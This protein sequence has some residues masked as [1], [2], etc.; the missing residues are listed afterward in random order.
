MMGA[1]VLPAIL[2]FILIFMESQITALIVSK[3]ERMLVKG[4]GFHVDLLIIVLVGGISAFFGLPWLSAATVRSVTHTNALTVMTK[5]NTPGE[6]P[7]ILEVKEQRV[8]GFLVAVFVGLSIVFGEA[9]RQI[10]LAVLF[11]IFLYMGVMS[12]NGIQL[13]ERLQLLLMPPKYHPE[14]S[15][16]Q[17]VSPVNMYTLIHR[18]CLSI[19]G[20][21]MATAAAL[22]F[23]FVLLLT[24]PVRM[25]L[26]PWIFTQQ[27]L[28]T[29]SV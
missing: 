25:L 23:P 27:E 3:K 5:P 9:L 21:V 17:K 15:Y 2:V 26:L 10:P 20:G 8:T 13:T 11:G 7:G 18:V 6:K 16:V 22:A 14:S 4:T 19:L 1:S 24:I 29:V 12:L 28:Q